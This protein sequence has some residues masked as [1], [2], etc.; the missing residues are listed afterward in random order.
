MLPELSERV[1]TANLVTA[2]IDK[3]FQ[4]TLLV[5]P[6]S[7]SMQWSARTSRVLDRKGRTSGS[8]GARDD[9]Y[10]YALRSSV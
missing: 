2:V 4:R 7:S 5:L 1:V 6:A 9:D 3:H 10:G 8:S